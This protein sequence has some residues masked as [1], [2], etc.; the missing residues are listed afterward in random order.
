[1]AIFHTDSP[2]SGNKEDPDQLNRTSFA[3]RIGEALKLWAESSPLVVSLEGPWGYGKT[4]VINLINLYYE[5]L[6]SSERPVV[7]SFNPWMIGNAENLV[8][9]FIVQFGS[10]VGLSSKGKNAQEAAKQLLAYSKVFNVLKWVPGAEP[11]ASIIEKVLNGAGSAT[12]K[13]AELKGLNINQKR[14]AVVKALNKIKRPI[15]V[16]IDDLDRLPPSEVFQMIRAVKAIT[17]FPRTTFLLAFERHYIENSLKSYGID[18]SSSYLDK[19]IQVRLHL[20][21]IAG[22][23]LHSLAV[24]ELQ[25]LANIELTSFF[26]GDQTRLSEI[27]HFSVKPLI[28]TPRELKRV[29]NRLRFIEPSIRK[30]VCFSD[31]FAL[32]VLAIKA[33]YVYEHIRTCPWA[34]NAQEPEYEFSLDKPED[35]L[36]KYE[37]ERKKVLETVPKEERIYIKE[38]I[39]KLFQQLDSGFSGGFRDMDYHYSR[40]HVASPDRLSFALTFGLPSGEI[41]SNLIVEFLNNPDIRENVIKDL[42]LG[43]TTERFIE[44]L[45]RTV[46]HRKPT[47]P[48]HFISSIAKIA[49]SDQAKSLQEKPRDM[50]KSGP[51]RQ[52]W[53]I[54]EITL[55]KLP[56]KDRCDIL[57]DLS[58]NPDFLTLSAFSLNY[59]LRQHGFY[60]KKDEIN[61]ELRWV[62]E[63]QLKQ[64][65]SQWIDSFKTIVDRKNLFYITDL[66]HVLFMLMRI[67]TQLS[68]QLV[69]HVIKKDDD[70]DKFVRSIG[71]SG[72]DSTKGEYSKVSEEL[73][74][75]FGGVDK[76]RERVKKRL[77]VGVED[78][79]LN[80]IYNSILTGEGYYLV[81]NTKTRPF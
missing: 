72:Q 33:P 23:D 16:F 4:S 13:I 65:K 26:E 76:I 43:N 63:N 20:P 15:I 45:L 40:G 71:R 79:A 29:Y 68:K 5:T 60:D 21:L 69:G 77:E 53:W 57:F 30:N 81:D 39:E 38:L 35:I 27:Y 56:T 51:V 61:E 22:E 75:S 73:L 64:L 28:K 67:D 24:S 7:F 58:R 74:D 12:E 10:A 8:Q 55:E 47:R 36:K 31:T 48:D 32:E 19:I 80:A 3:Q 6:D 54:A 62:D 46:K 50:L 37:S 66:T 70:L 78:T 41:S 59:C 49:S 1:M 18:D 17:D 14:T 44:L 52:L 25:S 11:W 9:E 42:Q 34:Y 2:I